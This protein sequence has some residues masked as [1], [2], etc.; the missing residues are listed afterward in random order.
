VTVFDRVYKS[1]Q[2]DFSNATE[3]S[4]KLGISTLTAKVL[5]NRGFST[6]SQCRDFLNTEV[7]NFFDPFLL[8]DMDKAIHRII[9]SIQKREKVCIYGDYDADGVTSST[10]LML[11]LSK[12]GANCFYYLPNRLKEGYGLNK[13]AIAR[14]KEMGAELIITVDCGITNIEE[15][16]YGKSIGLDI[17]VT[18]HHQCADILP[19]GYAVINPNRNDCQYP[20]KKLAGVGVAFKL[21]QALSVELNIDIDYEDIL[22]IV[23]IGT[24]ADVVSL[25]GE[26]RTIVK[27][28]L[29][30]IKTTSNPGVKA[31][32]EVAG[33]KDK[34]VYS[35]HLGFVLGPRLNA[36]GRL[37]KANIGVDM[38]L[39]KSYEDALILAKQLDDEN[40]KRQEIEEEILK[41]AEKIIENQIDLSKEK[42]I[43]LGSENWHSGVIGIVASKI[44]DKYYRPVIIFSNEGEY[45][46]GSARSIPSFN[47]YENL[48]RCSYLFERFGGHEQ[49]AGISIRTDR[50]EE[51]RN[52]I[53]LIAD[54]VLTEEDLIPEVTIDCEIEP[55]DINVEVGKELKELEPFGI[56]NPTPQ[57]IYRNA[58]V[59]SIRQIGKDNKHIKLVLEKCGL[60]V[61]TVGFNFGEYANIINNGDNVDI[62]AN[63]DINE[64]MGNTKAQLMIRDINGIRHDKPIVSDEYYCSFKDIILKKTYDHVSN[65]VEISPTNQENR[66]L[67]TIDNLKQLENVLVLVFNYYH[68]EEILNRIQTEGREIIK[69][70]SISYN[71]SLD[72]KVNSLVIL[73]FLKGIN[74]EKYNKILIYDLNF[75]S[76][77]LREFLENTDES[78]IEILG[79]KDD[80]IWNKKVLQGIL[81]TIEEMRLVYRVLFN[82]KADSFAINSEVY[83]NSLNI[84]YRTSITKAKFDIILEIFKECKFINF[85]LKENIYYIRLLG[86]TKE[87]IDLFQVPKVKYLYSLVN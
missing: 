17:I 70:T 79:N 76:N 75:D 86:K 48:K 63:L 27:N 73:P 31:L 38:F 68:A 12:I 80:I 83:V 87:K 60:E 59:K 28:G 67:Y 21:I 74:K 53:N 32:I 39:S 33:L 9:S 19:D 44:M 11:F 56:D 15:V 24:V 61:D 72:S 8:K 85:I 64:Y 36:G 35:Y 47:L 16:R 78:K 84:N 1:C 13:D 26:N 49:A 6:E 82:S 10:I 50:I 7:T 51:F 23:T 55:E 25:T 54:E 5:I 22:P 71:N 4:E 81:P 65:N 58:Q 62:I 43:V 42:V 77:N 37:G 20:F 40:T 46:R 2:S 69:K 30:F 3:I 52:T 45:S 57:F 66:L 41:E 34:D 18:D 29:K 14:I